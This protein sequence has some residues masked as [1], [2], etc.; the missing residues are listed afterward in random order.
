MLKLGLFATCFAI[1]SVVLISANRE[2]AADEKA[3]TIAE[4]MKKG[5][6]S[7][8]LVK[9]ITADVKDGNWKEAQDDAKLLK[10]FGESLGKNKPPKGSAESW[11]KLSAQYQVE[12]AAVALAADKK[13][14][15]GV[16]GA[17]SKLQKSCKACHDAHQ[18]E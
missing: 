10:S 4:I 12:T 3:P 1:G 7:K 17:I 16:N 9:R 15:D 8:G 18:E 5:H 6:G 2:I 13:D 11:K 14:A